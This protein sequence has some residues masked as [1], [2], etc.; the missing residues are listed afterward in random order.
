MTNGGCEMTEFWQFWGEHY[1]LAWCALW[2][3]WMI[4]DVL[5]LILRLVA[6]TYRLTMICL[7]GWPPAHLDAD[8][9]WKE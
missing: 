2:L 9:D 4:P 1:F 6:R 3:L 8:G 7:R 5:T